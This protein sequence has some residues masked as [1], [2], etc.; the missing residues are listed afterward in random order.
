M[1]VWVATAM[2]RQRALEAARVLSLFAVV[3][4]GTLV[5]EHHEQL[6]ANAGPLVSSCVACEVTVCHCHVVSPPFHSSYGTK[7][8]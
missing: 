3:A 4:S 7:H 1:M 5:A 8:P 6:Q 2:L